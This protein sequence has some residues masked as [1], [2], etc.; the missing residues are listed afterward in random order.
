MQYENWINI[1]GCGFLAHS[2][3]PNVHTSR[4]Q[5]RQPVTADWKISCSIQER[6]G[7][8]T[9]EEGRARQ[10]TASDHHELNMAP[11]ENKQSSPA[12]LYLIALSK[13]TELQVP[14]N[15]QSGQKVRTSH[16][17]AFSFV[18]S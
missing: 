11:M 12:C 10:F 7:A 15:I 18:K 14:V 5:T 3:R 6:A 16:F 9:A 2:G 1:G 13:L 8:S 4:C 17:F